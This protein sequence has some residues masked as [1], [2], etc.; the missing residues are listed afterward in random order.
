MRRRGARPALYYGLYDA[1]VMAD[2][3]ATEWETG[4][5]ASGDRR[6]DAGDDA[7]SGPSDQDEARVAHLRV[8]A[9]LMI[10]VREIIRR[11]GLRQRDAAA[12]FGVAQPRVSDLVRGKVA[13]F[14]VDTLI[15][16][17]AALGRRTDVKVRSAHSRP[18][19]VRP[20]PAGGATGAESDGTPA[21]GGAPGAGSR[22]AP[23]GR[24]GDA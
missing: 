8:R 9:E 18:A 1:S 15:D 5:T 21:G 3:R 12:L 16:M 10:A 7:V 19:A 20:G 23:R 2:A 22:A 4:G 24:R 17:L 11:R 14:S 6:A 13:L